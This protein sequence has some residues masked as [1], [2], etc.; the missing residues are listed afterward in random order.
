MR[1]QRGYAPPP[2]QYNSH[3]STHAALRCLLLQSPEPSHWRRAHRCVV[4]VPKAKSCELVARLQGSDLVHILKP[5]ELIEHRAE[6]CCGTEHTRGRVL[7]ERGPLRT[8]FYS[9]QLYSM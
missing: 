1:A 6:S 3:E 9:Y 4:R 2:L 8:A 5:V 7:L